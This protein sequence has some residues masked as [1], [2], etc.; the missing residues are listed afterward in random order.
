VGFELPVVVSLVEVSVALI[1][2]VEVALELVSILEVLGVSGGGGT[3]TLVFRGCSGPGGCGGGHFRCRG[4]FPSSH[5]GG[6]GGG[7][8]RRV[9]LPKTTVTF[10][11]SGG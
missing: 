2:A 9:S 10:F 4:P 5:G 7:M 8:K 11:G 1:E 3:V 6:G